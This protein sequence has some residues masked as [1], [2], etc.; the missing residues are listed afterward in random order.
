LLPEAKKTGGFF[1]TVQLALIDGHGFTGCFQLTG[2]PSCLNWT[3]KA[4]IAECA[5]RAACGIEASHSSDFDDRLPSPE[6]RAETQEF[7]VGFNRSQTLEGAN[8]QLRGSIHDLA[9][10]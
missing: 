3:D 10:R 7:E 4:A 2:G 1:I 5:E 6:A 8:S 9:R